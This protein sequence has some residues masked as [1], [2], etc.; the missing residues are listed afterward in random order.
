MAYIQFSEREKEMAN[1][2]DIASYLAM[3]GE[4]LKKCG[5]EY[6]WESPSGKVSIKGN[7]WYSQYERVGGGAVGFVQKFYGLSY[8][9]AVRSLIG[10]TAGCKF[11]RAELE[12]SVEERKPFIPPERNF[13]MRRVY[14]YLVG[15]RKISRDVLDAFVSKGLIYEDSKNHNVVFTGIDKCGNIRHAHKR[16]TNRESDYK[17]NVTGSDADYSFSYTG[18]SNSLFV[19]EAPIDMLAFISLHKTNWQEHSYVALCSTAE[20]AALRMLKDNPSIQ[21]I[22]LCLDHDSAG[23]E[24]CYRIAEAIQSF[25]N[26]NIH[27]K[28]PKNKDFDEDLKEKYG[29]HSIPSSE[30]VK[31]EYIRYA[32]EELKTFEI[33][34]SAEYSAYLRYRG[35]VIEDTLAKLKRA[36][37]NVS[38][39][40][41]YAYEMAKTCLAFCYLRN[42][43]H[44][45]DRDFTSYISE[46]K[47]LYKPHRDNECAK[48]IYEYLEKEICSLDKD[49]NGKHTVTESEFERQNAR[50]LL[51]ALDCLRYCGAC[52]REQAQASSLAMAM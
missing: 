29:I 8:P 49:L 15:E 25:G 37:I 11:V 32:C 19:F 10:N 43:Q 44:G 27:R 50:A 48:N 51:F 5:R 9:D 47:R 14:E 7:K 13:D 35:D 4:T 41:R 39:D 21:N 16:S 17:G 2:T 18:A 12:P 30:N 42:L 34:K 22:Y 36:F 24:G 40:T 46:M 31:L 3:Q 33:Y 20:K 45:E 26:Y 38:Y 52:K 6:S 1:S 23:I 28:S